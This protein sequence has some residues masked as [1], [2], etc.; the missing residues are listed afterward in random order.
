M[1]CYCNLM[2]VV[3]LAV[4]CAVITYR[5]LVQLAACCVIVTSHVCSPIA[6]LYPCM[7]AL[8]FT[9]YCIFLKSNVVCP[10]L[11]SSLQ[12]HST[13]RCSIA[14]IGKP[15]R[16]TL[17]KAPCGKTCHHNSKQTY[18]AW[19]LAFSAPANI[20]ELLGQMFDRLI[21]LS[22][23]VL[24]NCF[25]VKKAYCKAAIP[26]LSLHLSLSVA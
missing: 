7:L 10:E 15:V 19:H 8:Q 3:Q 5:S 25:I 17:L 26:T 23:F 18:L 21:W 20:W 1:L 22:G 4:H 16:I 9:G 24:N 14:V 6:L 13:R 12:P 2:F 11:N